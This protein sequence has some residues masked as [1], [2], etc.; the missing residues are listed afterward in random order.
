V[1]AIVMNRHAPF[2]IVILEHQGIILAG[3]V[4]TLG[5]HKPHEQRQQA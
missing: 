4:T 1:F 5:N 2:T 3:P